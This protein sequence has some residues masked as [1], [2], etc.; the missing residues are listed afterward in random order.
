MGC[1]ARWMEKF[2]T[3]SEQ[4]TNITA[5][6]QSIW[7]EAAVFL[8]FFISGAAALIYEISWARQ[9]GLLFGHTIH[10]AGVVLASYFAGMAVGYLIG[11]RW[12]RRVA[13][14][15]G[16]AFAEVVVAVWAFLIPILLNASEG[17][18]VMAVL[19]HDSF[20]W[21]TLSRVVFSFL[22]LLPATVALGITLPMIAVVCSSHGSGNLSDP[23]NTMR[24]AWA[25]SL[26]TAGALVGVCLATFYLLV[27]AG[28]TTS[29]YIAAVLSV[30]CALIAL[31]LQKAMPPRLVGS[32]ARDA[33][34][35]DLNGE[36]LMSGR[37]LLGLAAASGF[38]TLGL[39]VL[40]TRM[41]S[42]VFHNSTYTFGIV[43][44][45]FLAALALG[46][47]VVGALQRRL[48]TRRLAGWVSGFGA[49]ATVASVVLFIEFTDLEYFSYGD[50][51]STYM[52]GA[53]GLVTLVVG[54]PILLLGM[55]LPLIWKMEGGQAGDAVGW[56]TAVNTMAA[57]LGALSASFLLL[58]WVGLWESFALLGS[59]FAVCSVTL[60]WRS[61]NRLG[62]VAGGILFVLAAV[63]ALR[64]PVE[65]EYAR[66]KLGER[67][68]QRWNSP[69]GWIDAI[70]IERNG[71]Y[72]IRQN[73]HYR[74]GK[75]GSNTREFRQA[76]IPLLLHP[77]PEDVLFLGLGTGLTAGGSIS[78]EEVKRIDIAEL[79]PEVVDACRLLAD[80]NFNVI[81]HP[82]TDVYVDDGRHYLLGTTRR[83]D[84][85]VS[86][87]FVPWESESG[88]LYTVE[89]Y[90]VAK[91]RLKTDGIFCQWL[92][93]FQLGE[94]EFEAIADSFASVFPNVTI[95][96]A[97]LAG[98][99]PVV[100]LVGSNG[101]LKVS[102][103]LV[104]QRLDRLWQQM[105]ETDFVLANL[106]Q[107]W[108]LYLGDW[109]RRPDV[110][111]NTDEHPR[112]EFLTPISNR[113]RQLISSRVLWDYYHQ[114]LVKLPMEGAQLTDQTG[115]AVSADQRRARQK[116]MMFGK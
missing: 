68:I 35:A 76:H 114:V 111:L 73:L 64:S 62:V 51:F 8:I 85:I 109:V 83:Y 17:S 57:A 30:V 20:F 45:V 21:Q 34:P 41:F 55:L 65:V 59:L 91:Q 32:G 106:D 102:G 70:Q 71:I 88:Y 66:E 82:R 14:L 53:V 42:L 22:L 115:S 97:E 77:D 44:A 110:N 84:V 79:I 81:D 15:R 38:G 13:P 46:A 60:L 61:F 89:H 56:L 72:K 99:K 18:S 4:V 2:V 112:V 69:Y 3:P 23:K 95:W 103:N 27:H 1:A 87:L 86:D 90:E 96:W 92:P 63:S 105:G 54:P 67:L 16:Y 26:N 9:V 29:S 58:P 75:T 98:S 12:S 100:G 28:V 93:L 33:S 52:M 74:F 101:P 49:I 80:H 10:A 104:T 19:T 37:A 116:L 47:A 48:S 5:G 43:I 78:H 36:P 107:F 24:V 40:Y 94:G 6:R 11:A 7:I 108:N 39:Q 113:D 50:S 31:V 25:Y